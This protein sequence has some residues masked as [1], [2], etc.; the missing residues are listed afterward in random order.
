MSEPE[1]SSVV[2]DPTDVIAAA[3][4]V[5][6]APIDEVFVACGI[7][8]ERYAATPEAE[9]NAVWWTPA[10][11]LAMAHYF[12]QEANACAEVVK[13]LHAGADAV[14]QAVSMEAIAATTA[15]A[16]GIS[17][18]IS[19]VELRRFFA[20]CDSAGHASTFVRA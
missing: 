1:T 8:L 3:I 14:M 16:E 10:R 2:E 15:A 7:D 5:L 18:R 13:R 6:C 17:G 19:F 20:R 9:R 4:R 12:R 11:R